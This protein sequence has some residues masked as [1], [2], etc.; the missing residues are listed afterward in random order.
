MASDRGGDHG[1]GQRLTARDR[2][3]EGDEIDARHH[4][5][6]G[7]LHLEASVHL[8]E[9][10]GAV[11]ADD[12]LDGPGIHVV[13]GAGGSLG[14]AVEVTAQRVVEP[15]RRCLLDDLLM[16]AL[17]RAVA[18]EERRHPAVLVGDDLDLDV[19]GRFDVLLEEQRAVTERAHGFALRA[20]HRVDEAVAGLDDAHAPAAAAR[21]RLHDHRETDA[22]GGREHRVG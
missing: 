22:V 3:L 5:G 11:G 2:D 16:A 10:E 19:T 15:G 18:F 12:E 21:R 14:R 8:E 6:D 1:L 7:M 20:R 9:A 17:D 13:D 4:L